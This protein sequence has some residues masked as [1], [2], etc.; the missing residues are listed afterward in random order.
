MVK[1]C[2]ELKSLENN[3]NLNDNNVYQEQNGIEIDMESE[4]EVVEVEDNLK[5]QKIAG[6]SLVTHAPILNPSK[7]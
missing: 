2:V 3:E 1:M 7:E 4:D 5:I 6:G